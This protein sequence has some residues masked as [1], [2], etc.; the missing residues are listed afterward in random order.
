MPA[1][2]G[3]L[4][5]IT[6]VVGAI[7]KVI[8]GSVSFDDQK[9]LFH[10]DGNGV[11]TDYEIFNRYEGD[12]HIYMLGLTSPTPFQGKSVAFV[13]IAAPTLL[14]ICEWT[15]CRV[16]KIPFVP[17]PVVSDPNWV[18]LDIYYETAGLAYASDGVSPLYRLSG[19]YVYG[20]AN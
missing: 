8:V 9:A 1:A 18:L 10:N 11:W 13:Q 19:V 15:S 4:Q 7:T 17:N 12:K 20:H 16:T 2:P 6:G 3:V 5:T 14:W